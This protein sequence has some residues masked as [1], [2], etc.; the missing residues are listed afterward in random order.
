MCDEEYVYTEGEL[1]CL[2]DRKWWYFFLSSVFTFLA[3]LAVVLVWRALA[4]VCCRKDPPSDYTAPGLG[5]DGLP[6]KNGIPLGPD[7]G[8]LPASAAAGQRPGRQPKQEFEGTFMTEAKDWAGELI[9]GQTTT[10]RILVSQTYPSH[11]S[12]LYG[13][14]PMT[15]H[16]Q[17]VLVFF[18]S[19]ASLVIYF[20]DASAAGVEKC[21]EW[22]KNTTQQIDLAFNIFFMVYFFIRV[23]G[24]VVGGGRGLRVHNLL[25]LFLF[26]SWLRVTSCGSCWRCTHSSTTSRSRPLSSPSTWTGRGSGSGS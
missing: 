10:G 19:I 12:P 16:L 3:G 21:E 25:F 23:S 4:F 7:L 22:S 24:S 20:I 2:K 8:Q 17:V 14:H 5:P 26:S 6:L 13:K 11:P 1:E 15:S 9:S 18:L